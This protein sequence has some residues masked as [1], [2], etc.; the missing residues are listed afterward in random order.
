MVIKASD[1]DRRNA[2]IRVKAVGMSF[3]RKRHHGGKYDLGEIVDL[4]SLKV[5]N[6]SLEEWL[7]SGVIELVDGLID[8]EIEEEK[9]EEI[10]DPREGVDNAIALW[11]KYKV[12][13]HI[14]ECPLTGKKWNSRQKQ[15]MWDSYDDM[16]FN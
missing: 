1:I 15:E 2:K 16:E 7:E 3:G 14:S 11:K 5:D 6:D 10:T 9:P 4:K 12:S 8:E 13:S